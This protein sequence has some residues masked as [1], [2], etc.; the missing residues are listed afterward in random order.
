MNDTLVRDVSIRPSL[1]LEETVSVPTL[2]CAVAAVL[3]V[4]AGAALQ[5]TGAVLTGGVLAAVSAVLFVVDSVRSA[6]STAPTATD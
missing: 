2:V 5:L 3:L 6:R 4:V 1:T